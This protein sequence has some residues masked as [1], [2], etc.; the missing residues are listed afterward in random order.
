MQDGKKRI[1][2]HWFHLLHEV[3]KK[4]KILH[5]PRNKY[6]QIHFLVTSC[7]SNEIERKPCCA[8]YQV[9]FSSE[10][11]SMEMILCEVLCVRVFCNALRT[12]LRFQCNYKEIFL[13]WTKVH[14][15]YKYIIL[16]CKCTLSCIIFCVCLENYCLY[17]CIWCKGMLRTFNKFRFFDSLIFAMEISVLET[18]YDELSN[19]LKMYQHNRYI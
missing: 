1:G 8:A 13:M 15:V 17:T 2:K 6:L 10:Y 7:I 18:A 12:L 14:R 3:E 19:I 9:S 11:S 5:Q 16:V 4:K